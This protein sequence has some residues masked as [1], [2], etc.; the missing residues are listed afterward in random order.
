M[1]F[2]SNV[3]EKLLFP[4]NQQIYRQIQSGLD[5]VDQ[6]HP[7]QLKRII[8]IFTKA[9]RSDTQTAL[10]VPGN[11]DE[12]LYPSLDIFILFSKKEDHKNASLRKSTD[13]TITFNYDEKTS[14]QFA[15]SH[16]I[17]N[18]YQNSVPKTF[19]IPLAYL[20][21]FN[22]KAV[23][24]EGSFQLYSHN[25]LSPEKSAVINRNFRNTGKDTFNDNFHSA[26]KSF[27]KDSLV[28][29]GITRRT[30]QERYRQHCCDSGRGSN[31]L[32][33]RALRGE[34]CKIGTIE[35][36]VERAGLTE[37]QA[38]EI[39]EKEVENR[40]LRSLYKNGLNMIP[41]GYA[42]LKY[43]QHFAART[44]Y[45]M[46]RELTADTVESVLVDIQRQSLEKLFKTAVIER[47]NAEIA[48]LWA[49]DPEYRI[50]VM[51]NR[52]NRFSFRQIQAARIWYASGWLVEKIIANL[53][54]LDADRKIN[55]EQLE[56]LLSGKTYSSIPEVLM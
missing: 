6:N 1:K 26:Q 12:T 21:G 24:K 13:C 53:Q 7:D 34:F 37:K 17:L 56:R 48:R 49:E 5:E 35:H 44:G 36:I 52:H 47:I 18:F 51:T 27:Q 54:K 15:G 28:Y 11:A 4:L 39:E 29:V 33:H 22:E 50:N 9:A 46:Q 32:F 3:F 23:L 2:K 16:L 43:I 41:G 10:W 42:G 40:S 55:E 8:E 31:L 38:M 19:I 25:I 20:L 14:A 30:W 45:A